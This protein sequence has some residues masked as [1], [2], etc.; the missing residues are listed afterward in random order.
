MIREDRDLL[1]EL[2]RLNCAMPSFA[3][4]LMDGSADAAAQRRYAQRLIAVGE[5]LQRRADS[6]AGTVVE[7]QVLLDHTAALPVPTRELSR[8]P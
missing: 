6:M 4:Q 2:A 7:G 3:L 1:T 5:Q 8:E